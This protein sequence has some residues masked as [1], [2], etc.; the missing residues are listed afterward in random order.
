MLIEGSRLHC[1]LGLYHGKDR[2]F[3]N[4]ISHSHTRS[5]RRWE[6]NVQNKRV[7]SEALNDWI[8]FKMTTKAMKEADNVGGIDN[9]ILSLDNDAVAD[10]NYVTKIRGIIANKLY[11]RGLLEDRVIKRLGFDK[12]PPLLELDVSDS[13]SK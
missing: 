11:H 7:W 1:I 10:S 9:Y 4:S 13:A 12:V 5:K 8:Q 2:L 3:G 6:P